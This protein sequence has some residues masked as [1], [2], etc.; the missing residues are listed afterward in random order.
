M[1]PRPNGTDVRESELP[2]D[3]LRR[4][5]LYTRMGMDNHS[6]RVAELRRRVVEQ[7]PDLAPP[8]NESAPR[9]TAASPD[10]QGLPRGHV[11]LSMCAEWLR[12]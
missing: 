12:R 3:V 10:V 11:E 1:A 6:Q 5:E 8:K 2:D 9:A 4:M 7:H